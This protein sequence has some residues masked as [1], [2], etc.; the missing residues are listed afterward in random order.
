VEV[1]A[2]RIVS[3]ALTNV[4]RHARARTCRITVGRL[5]AL[6]L[7]ITDD[8]VGLTD[9]VRHGVG[10]ASMRERAAELGGD[11]ELTAASPRGTAVRVRLP[12]HRA[13]RLLAARTT[14]AGG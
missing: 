14:Q 2:Y 9:P 7:E 4:A 6:T 10:L 8:G 12:L 3:E 11:C 1:A 5:R 13:E